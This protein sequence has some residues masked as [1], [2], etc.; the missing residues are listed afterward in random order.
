MFRVK[1]AESDGTRRVAIVAV[2]AL[3]VLALAVTVWVM[4]D[5]LAEQQIVRELIRELPVSAKNKAEALEGE[6]RW[7]F[8]LSILI[9][10]NLV[11]TGFAVVLLARAYRSSQESLRDLKALAGDILSCMDQAVITTDLSGIVTSINRRGLEML[12]P[13]IN[14]VGH[15]LSELSRFVPIEQ[16]RK[17]WIVEKSVAMTRDFKLSANGARV[18]RAFCQTLSDIDDQEIGFVL[19]LRDVTDRFLIESR[20]RRMERYMGLGSLAAGLHHEIKNPLTALSLHV[21]LLKEQL[22]D[23]AE[24][25]DEV[26]HMLRVIETEVARVGGVLEGFRDFASIGK[27]NLAC[28]D[29]K[30]LI[31]RQIDLITPQ[32]SA[33]SVAID[34]QLPKDLPQPFADS[35]RLEQVLLNIIVNALD[36]M[37]DG[38]KVT[39]SAFADSESICVEVS[40]TG[41]GVPEELH[42]KI[43]DPYFT[44]KDEGTGLGLALCD[45]IMRQHDGSLEFRSSPRGTV[46][47]LNFSLPTASHASANE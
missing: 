45:K 7:Q 8:R 1:Q 28:V 27:L 32:A 31:Q 47:Q 39:I 21:Q 41:C 29:L 34:L 12:R 19:Q 24:S 30:Q 2:L 17:D 4:V 37:P 33:Q 5:F 23:G 14:C 11:V 42:D 20:M 18:L 44:T 40:D 25:C 9:V 35:G 43:F 16:F 22:S 26:R 15:P 3:S 13:E 38:G 6:L 36:A 46:F 10:L